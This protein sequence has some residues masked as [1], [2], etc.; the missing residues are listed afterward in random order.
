MVSMSDPHLDFFGGLLWYLEARNWAFEKI[1]VCPRGSHF[2][3][4][5]MHHAL[6]FVNLLS[7][8]E[9]VCD[10]LR[11]DEPAHRAF[12]DQIEDGFGNTQNYKYVRE[13]RN[14]IVHRGVDPT[15]A[16]HADDTTVYVLCPTAVQDRHG[17]ES[18]TCTFRYMVELATHCNA[19]TNAVIADALDHLDLFNP[20]QHMVSEESVYATID[21]S[22]AMPDWA[23]AMA[24]VV[25]RDMNYGVLATDL[26]ATRIKQMRSLL[27][28]PEVTS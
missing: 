12:V 10:H 18:Y 4:I 20:A 5:R 17:K 22:T 11:G 24:R 16:G 25:F 7:A 26:A 1:K 21:D 15:A 8:V 2:F 27:G 14:A 23:K 6:Y 3:D 9:H 19:V 13:L 28:L